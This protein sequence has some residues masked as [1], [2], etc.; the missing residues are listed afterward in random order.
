MKI[1]K[2]NLIIQD[3]PL[4]VCCWQCKSCLEIEEKDLR[5]RETLGER[6]FCGVDCPVCGAIGAAPVS[7]AYESKFIS[8]RDLVGKFLYNVFTLGGLLG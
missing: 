1:K 7:E 6:Q 5:V 4:I 8:D 3:F 2:V